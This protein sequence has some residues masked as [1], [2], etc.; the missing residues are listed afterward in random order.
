M[1]SP[2]LAISDPAAGDSE[3]LL[4]AAAGHRLRRVWLEGQLGEVLQRDG[5][6][7]EREPWLYQGVQLLVQLLQHQSQRLDLNLV[8]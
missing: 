1:I 7:I 5:G 4:E 8:P 3:L 6:A 2:V